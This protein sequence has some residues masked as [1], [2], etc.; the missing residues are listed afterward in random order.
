[1]HH[2]FKRGKNMKYIW[3]IMSICFFSCS[4][5]SMNEENKNI[6]KACEKANSGPLPKRLDKGLEKKIAT[7]KKTDP[8]RYNRL[9]SN[10]EKLNSRTKQ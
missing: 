10:S 6:K 1:M 2:T 3:Y 4:L 5:Y 8:Q 9:V 7:I